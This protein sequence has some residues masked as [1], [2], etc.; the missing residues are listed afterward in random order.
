MRR[1]YILRSSSFPSE[2]QHPVESYSTKLSM[3]ADHYD[4]RRH[5]V[6]E[7]PGGSPRHA[8]P[9][10]EDNQSD[11]ELCVTSCSPVSRGLCNRDEMMR[12]E[13]RHGMSNRLSPCSSGQYLIL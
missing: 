7:S 11:D 2:P 6:T 12:D 8:S 9:A 3:S 1:G 5:Y 4:A 10:T 13:L